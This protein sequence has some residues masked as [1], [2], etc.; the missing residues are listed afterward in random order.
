[1]GL[2]KNYCRSLDLKT[3][4][5]VGVIGFPNVGKSSLI[6]S[7]KRSRAV[8]VS[9]IAGFTKTMQEVQLDKLVKLLDCPGVV[10]DDA[11]GAATLLKNCV[12]CES[13]PDPSPAVAAVLQRCSRE[14]LM[15]IYEI[16]K[17][18]VGDVQAFLALVAKKM[19]KL[20]K[21]GTPDRVVAGRKVLKDWNSGRVPYYTLPPTDT[22]KNTHV[23]ETQV[24]S[25][26]GSEFDPLAVDAAAFDKEMLD[27]L[28][29]VQA[30]D[31]LALRSA[32]VSHGHWTAT[33]S[34]TDDMEEDNEA[35]DAESDNEEALESMA[36]SEGGKDTME[37][38]MDDDQ[39]SEEE[40]ETEEKPISKAPKAEKKAPTPAAKLRNALA[41]EKELNP[42]K[43]AD[44]KKKVKVGKKQERRLQKARQKE[45][46]D[47]EMNTETAPTEHNPAPSDDDDL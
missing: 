25:Q 43:G 20:L 1:M 24:V 28:P 7:L 13:L 46:L 11:D 23:G 38:V 9:P 14:Q 19:G 17:F 37:D 29:A 5:T 16:P 41:R 34:T 39:S 21:G 27:A 40:E 47:K 12:D 4:I 30:T 35:S 42:R 3:A 31:C 6:N 8:G 10:F 36:A 26:F 44:L 2:L 18:D 33:E 45:A 15:Q 32:G 22:G